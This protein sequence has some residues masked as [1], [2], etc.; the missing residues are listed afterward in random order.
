MTWFEGVVAYVIIWWVVIF[1]VL[2]FGV[3]PLPKGDPGHAAGAPAHP[4]LALKVAVTTVVAA[5]IWLGLF[6]AVRANLVSFR[7]S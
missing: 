6:A 1:A 7:P 3:R 5:L 4:R 2:P